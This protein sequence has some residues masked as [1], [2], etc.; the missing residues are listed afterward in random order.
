MG[1][2]V[3]RDRMEVEGVVI[4]SN[5]GQFKVKVN[6][7]HIVLCTLSGKIRMN[8]VKVVVGDAVICEISIHQLD[9]GRI[10][11]RFKE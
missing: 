11:R 2:K 8:S 1:N 10:V 5:R 6:D 9:R 3:E 4:E 7:T